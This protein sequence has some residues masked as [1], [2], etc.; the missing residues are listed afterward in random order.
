MVPY[1]HK[2]SEMVQKMHFVDV[3]GTN[4]YCIIYVGTAPSNGSLRDE[5][6][7]QY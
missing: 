2:F 6:S 1:L 7:K 5:F 4:L 3:F